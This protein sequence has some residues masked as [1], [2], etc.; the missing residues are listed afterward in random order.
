[1]EKIRKLV[2]KEKEKRIIFEIDKGKDNDIFDIL[3][4]PDYKEVSGME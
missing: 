1:M 4:D 3:N 2:P